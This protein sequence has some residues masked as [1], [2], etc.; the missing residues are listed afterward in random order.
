MPKYL[1][2]GY[3]WSENGKNTAKYYIHTSHWQECSNTFISSLH[4]LLLNW[5]EPQPPQLYLIADNHSTNKSKTM[6]AYLYWLC[7]FKR[8]YAEI[9]L[10]FSPPYHGKNFVDQCHQGIAAE[11]NST[12][13]VYSLDKMVEVATKAKNRRFQAHALVDIWNWDEYF[14]EFVYFPSSI[15]VDAESYTALFKPFWVYR[16]TYHGVQFRRSLQYTYGYS[17]AYPVLSV[18]PGPIIPCMRATMLEEGSA[19]LNGLQYSFKFLQQ[20]YPTLDISW[21]ES[22]LDGTWESLNISAEGLVIPDE[23]AFIPHLPPTTN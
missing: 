20:A 16:I 19:Q 22:V 5:D 17:T 23:F 13:V 7:H 18:D 14:E 6:L 11:L 21:L 2:G 8:M 3:V 12:E 15:T 1:L 10:I 9:H 4:H